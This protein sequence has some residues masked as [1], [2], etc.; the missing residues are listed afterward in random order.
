MSGWGLANLLAQAS[1]LGPTRNPT[2]DH[3]DMFNETA[4]LM[5]IR[6]PDPCLGPRYIMAVEELR[7]YG[8]QAPHQLPAPKEWLNAV[9]SLADAVNADVEA[10]EKAHMGRRSQDWAQFVDWAFADKVGVIHRATKLKT[11]WMSVAVRM[12]EGDAAREAGALS[13]AQCEVMLDQIQEYTKHWKARYVAPLARTDD[14][15]CFPRAS[16]V[17]LRAIFQ[18]FNSSIL[19]PWTGSTPGFTASYLTRSWSVW[20]PFMKPTE[21][22]ASGQDRYGTCH[23][24]SFESQKKS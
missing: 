21:D 22:R 23:S 8:L 3:I 13:A 24:L 4:D 5:A 11:F 18:S 9:R 2:T 15:Q 1:A 20:P 19:N 17:S 7:N 10:A 14:R 6:E 16:A 12:P